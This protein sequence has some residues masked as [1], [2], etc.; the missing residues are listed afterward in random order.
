M[1]TTRVP[2][3]TRANRKGEIGGK[4]YDVT[5]YPGWVSRVAVRHGAEPET[6]IYNQK[7]EKEKDRNVHPFVLPEGQEKRLE[8]SLFEFSGGPHGKPWALEIHDPHEAIARIEITLKAPAGSGN[9]AGGVHAMQSPDPTVVV[10]EDTPV[11]CPPMC[12]PG[13]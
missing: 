7:G 6:E 3:E 11:L 12:E 4:S 8:R 1:S 10:L 9:G 2:S 13:E 5:F